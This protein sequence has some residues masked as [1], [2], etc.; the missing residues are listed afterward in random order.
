MSNEMLMTSDEVVPIK[1][2][3]NIKVSSKMP[4]DIQSLRQS[5]EFLERMKY[6]PHLWQPQEVVQDMEAAVH[7]AR[8][9]LLED[10]LKQHERAVDIRIETEPCLP[11]IS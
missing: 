1:I 8:T 3:R 11:T 6:V 10:Q 7:L 5:K 4:F 9:A 2:P